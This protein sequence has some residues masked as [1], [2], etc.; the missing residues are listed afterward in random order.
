MSLPAST[1]APH[2]PT[3]VG[4]DAPHA[5]PAPEARKAARGFDRPR[6]KCSSGD[7]RCAGFDSRRA[8]PARAHRYAAGLRH[9]ESGA[10]ADGPDR[11]PVP[12]LPGGS[13]STRSDA[14]VSAERGFEQPMPTGGG[15]VGVLPRTSSHEEAPS[16]DEYRGGVSPHE[17]TRRDRALHGFRGRGWQRVRLRYHRVTR[18]ATAGGSHRRRSSSTA[19]SGVVRPVRG[20]ARLRGGPIRGFLQPRRRR[21][22]PRQLG[23]WPARGPRSRRVGWQCFDPPP[24]W[25]TTSL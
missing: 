2:G 10:R 3:R 8:G 19:R 14:G 7:R 22:A 11:V 21:R 24:A 15:A 4:P 13:P 5:R 18:S 23:R 6:R 16:E 17:G 12:C 1:L 9:D 20:E 25:S